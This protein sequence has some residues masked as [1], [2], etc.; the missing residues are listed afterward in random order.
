M[1]RHG[2][3]AEI[4]SGPGDGTEVELTLKVGGE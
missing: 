1:K 2:G 3:K 4:R